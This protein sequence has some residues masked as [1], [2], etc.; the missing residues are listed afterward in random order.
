MEMKFVV[1][2][3]EGNISFPQDKKTFQKKKNT[4]LKNLN[5]LSCFDDV[6]LVEKL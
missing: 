3:Y 1:I 4:K 5:S 6:F 2:D